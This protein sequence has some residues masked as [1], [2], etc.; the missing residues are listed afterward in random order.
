MK[1]HRIGFVVPS[2]NV[3][4]ETE[5]PELLHRYE[6]SSDHRFTFHS[7]RSTL[8]SVDK[9]S[10]HRML[11]DADRCAD[12]LSDA[13]VEVIGYA[14]LVA[15]MAEGPKAHEALERRLEDITL[16]NDAK[17]T[18]VSSAGALVRTLHALS[19]HRVAIATPYMPE[20]T[21]LVARYLSDYDIEVV[22][23]LSLS[24]LDNRAVGR[25]DPFELAQHIK[26]L[27]LRRADGLVLSA[28]VQMP[29]LSVVDGVQNSVGIPVVTAATA[30]TRGLLEALGLAP[31]VAG[32]GAALADLRGEA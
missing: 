12:E 5:V 2:S 4:I 15:L 23:T 10:L 6:Q 13:Q 3:T 16:E 19:L 29:S 22:D 27:D 26:T 20:L 8:H 7:S 14:C 9:D 32:G 28:C 25:L 21:A 17:A 1:T 11:D 24:V 18:I 30:T 31:V